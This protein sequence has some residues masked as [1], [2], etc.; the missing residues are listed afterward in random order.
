M[1]TGA[2]SGLGRSTALRFAA[3]GARVVMVDLPSEALEAAMEEVQREAA[4]AGSI[5][6]CG[7][8]VTSADD[9]GACACDGRV[10]SL[11][12]TA[13][14]AASCNGVASLPSRLPAG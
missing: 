2:A 12:M 9:V 10:A 1:I 3:A 6:A 14:F 7:A 8:D 13:R 11:N 4:S 5:V